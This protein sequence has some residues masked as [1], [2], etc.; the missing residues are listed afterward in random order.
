[1]SSC[2]V[3]NEVI[4]VIIREVNL[5]FYIAVKVMLFLFTQGDVGKGGG[6]C[7][8]HRYSV[9]HRVPCFLSSRPLTR[10]QVVPPPPHWFLGG[11]TPA[12][13]GG[14]HSNKGTD[15]LVLQV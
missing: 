5:S 15:T 14:S 1:M 8:L 3:T 2:G 4:K 12:G 7:L 10:K 13:G 9:S 11:D 6:G